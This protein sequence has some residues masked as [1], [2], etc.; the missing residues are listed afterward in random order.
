[1]KKDDTKNSLMPSGIIDLIDDRAAN[2][3]YLT[4]IF[5]SKL[6]PFNYL[7]FVELRC[8]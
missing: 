8:W 7:D 1:M 5:S 2:E 3:F 4:Q 6:V